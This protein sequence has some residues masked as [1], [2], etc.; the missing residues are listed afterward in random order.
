MSHFAKI[1][2]GIVTEV[3]VSEQD[4]IDTL[5]GQWVQTSYNTQDGIHKLGG[6]PMRKNYASI[7]FV[8]DSINDCFDPPK[9]D[10]GIK[11]PPAAATI[12]ELLARIETL[13]NA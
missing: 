2:D 10:H 8:Y 9:T 3:I 12:E 11:A 7:G 13:E 1:E 4:H 5:I 6:V